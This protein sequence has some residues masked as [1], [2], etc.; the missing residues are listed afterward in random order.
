MNCLMNRPSSA[1]AVLDLYTTCVKYCLDVC[2]RNS[3]DEP[4]FPM[5]YS[6]VSHYFI[7]MWPRIPYNGTL[8]AKASSLPLKT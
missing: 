4:Y 6:E 1:F 2:G 8:M 3:I 5:N 7:A